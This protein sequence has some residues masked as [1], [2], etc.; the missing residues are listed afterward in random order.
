MSNFVMAKSVG[1][2]S[3][4]C[5]SGVAITSSADGSDNEL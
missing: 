3:E 5:R 2:G 1:Y 4:T